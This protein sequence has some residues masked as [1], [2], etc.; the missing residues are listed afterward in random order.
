[1]IDARVDKSTASDVL[2]NLMHPLTE[3]E[4][5]FLNTAPELAQAYRFIGL[6]R[7]LTNPVV[8]FY[9]NPT[10]FMQ[11]I[12][13]TEIERD[14]VKINTCAQLDAYRDRF[15]EN[16]KRYNLSYHTNKQVQRSIELGFN[17]VYDAKGFN[18]DEE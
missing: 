11:L 15:I 14:N 6:Y 9:S 16:M 18:D 5:N 3:Y 13:E 12:I 17:N 1:M 2:M 7:L 4:T 10:W 8:E